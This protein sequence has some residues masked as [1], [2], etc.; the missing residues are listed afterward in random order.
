MS[1]VM[2][3]LQQQLQLAAGGLTVYA[4]S[5]VRHTLPAP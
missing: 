1:L 2:K 3:P 4:K 5:G